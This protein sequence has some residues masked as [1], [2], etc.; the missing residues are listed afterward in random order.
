MTLLKW[1][2]LIAAVWI[3]PAT[4]GNARE[5]VGRQP[6]SEQAGDRPAPVSRKHVPLNVRDF[7]AKGDG[8]TDDTDAIQR[9]LLQAVSADYPFVGY[10]GY[11]TA[12][13]VRSEEK[14]LDRRQ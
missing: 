10:R 5:N 11:V 13:E 2:V 8:V 1:I 6:G 12:P 7:G 9:C 14:F 3:M 4:H